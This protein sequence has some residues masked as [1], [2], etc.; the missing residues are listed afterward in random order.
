MLTARVRRC[1]GAAAR[2]QR[3]QNFFRRDRQVV[4][5]HADRVEDRIG[6]SRQHRIGAHLA[7]ALGAERSVRRGPFK[8][9]NVVRTDVARTRHQIF[10]EIARAVSRIRIIRLRRLIERVAHAHP[11]AADELLFDQF[12][13]DRAPDLVGAGHFQHGD[14]AGLVVDF[15]FGDQT[16]MGVA[17]RRRHFAGLRIDVGQRH[18]ENAASGNRL[19]LAELRGDGDIA[20]RDRAVRRAFHAN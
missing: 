13:I 9:D 3:P 16:G 18:Q 11:G 14:F 8:H 19:A 5:A 17:S 15:D 10:V 1:R 7:R 2:L 20:H 4:D 6:D 12:G